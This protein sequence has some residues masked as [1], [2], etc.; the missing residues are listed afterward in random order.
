MDATHLDAT[1]LGIP[2]DLLR[3]I[4]DRNQAVQL[5]IDPASGRIVE[6][7]PAACRFYGR[8]REEL[9]SLD[10]K[11]IGTLSPAQVGEALEQAAA[12]RRSRFLF[13]HQLA[14]GER[15]DVEVLW[16]PVEVGSQHLLFSIVHDL[17]DQTR[18]ED[19]LLKVSQAFAA[20]MDGLAILRADETY[21]FLNEA[22]AR[23]YGYDRTE[24]LLGKSW[25]A[26]YEPGEVQRFEKDVM[27]R[28][29]AEGRWRGEA[30]GRRRDGSTFPQELSLSA[31]PGGG[32]VC[33]VRDITEAKEAAKLQSALYRIAETTSAAEDMDTFY[34][35]MHGIVGELMEARNFYIALQDEESGLL[36]FPYFVDQA[37]PPPVPRTP[38]RG[39]TEYVLRTGEPLL[40]DPCA[41]E[42]LLRSG[43]I[44]RVGAP[45]VDWLGVPLKRGENTFG[46][47]AVQSYDEE[48]RFTPHH[49]ELLTFVSQ[50]VAAAI[51]RWR[52]RDALRRSEERFRALAETAPCAIFIYQG[53]RFRYANPASL[54]MTGYSIAET[55]GMNARHILDPEDQGLLRGRAAA[56]QR[57]QDV[58]GHREFKIRRKDGEVRWLDYSAAAIEYQGR[59]ATLGAAFD[60]TERKRADEHIKSLAYH[61]ALTGLPNRLLFNDRLSLA[62]AQAHRYQ[63]K[64]AVLFLDL[65]R[66]KVINDSLGHAL[67]DRLLQETASRLS[68][69]VR[70]GDTVARIGGDEFVLLL[71]G[72]QRPVE[73]ARVAE[74][75]LDALREPRVV[76][77]H[78]LV[79]TA[80]VGISLYPDD[81]QD[82]ETLVK[83]ADT[84]LY[85]AKEQGR[86]RYQLFT[87]SM[88][89]GA[90]ERLVLENGLRR[91]LAQGELRIHYQPLLDLASGRIDGVEALLRWQDPERGLLVPAADFIALAEMTGLIVP[92]GPF[93]L[94]TACS[95]VRAWQKRGHPDLRVAVNLSARQLQQPDLV[96]QVSEALTETGLDA[97]F[98]ELEITEAPVAQGNEATHETLVRLKALG[99]RISMDDFGI[100]N[101]SLSALKR[102]PVDALKID[103]SFVRNLVSDPDDAAVA[104]AV[105]ALGHTLQLQVIA[106]GVETEE[107]R[108]FLA[109]LK[110]DRIQGHLFSEPV[111]A[112]ACEAFLARHQA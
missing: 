34:A 83:Q 4:F 68:T 26:L 73:V 36:S 88:N 58:R 64:L 11:D 16:G 52:A 77:G 65:D 20:A 72:I 27:P 106:E 76:D 97:R 47:L 42:E 110:C 104:S 35:A 32:L 1:P 25:R 87:P 98:L 46:V 57:G 59:P 56:R 112:E 17:T 29:W 103:R 24:E 49:R 8:S 99:A 60:I 55:I 15:K 63:Q 74:K 21:G 107:Q 7:N 12:G 92:I 71:P 22:H 90:L 111:P 82:A 41:L 54:A 6:A 67:G 28:L 61:D 93:V 37:D 105:I 69:C 75:V 89:A 5:L 44:E 101:S 2:G 94:R 40:V 62:V 43:A 85:R 33:V 18:A 100:G 3:Q 79:V 14:S 84:A 66:F 95:Q 48:V 50:H 51:D 38:V 81:G 80:T 53:N 19:A 13:K 86:N 109:A 78:E 31:I 39:L 91:A 108:A 96:A 23:V 9:T 45:C 10:I 70:E 30:V 102:L